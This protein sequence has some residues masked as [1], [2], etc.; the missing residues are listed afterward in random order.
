M[1]RYVTKVSCLKIDKKSRR[2][3]T[4]V[5][6]ALF[7]IDVVEIPSQ[8]PV[9]STRHIFGIILCSQSDLHRE[10]LCLPRF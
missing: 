10:S 4:L 1:S 9:N 8:N 2:N 7:N 5:R 6:A 3:K